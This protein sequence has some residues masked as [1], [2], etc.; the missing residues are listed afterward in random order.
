MPKSTQLVGNHAFTEEQ[1]GCCSLS[2]QQ[3]PYLNNPQGPA[4]H[5]INTNCFT[6]SSYTQRLPAPFL[7]SLPWLTPP[8]MRALRS[9]SSNAGACSHHKSS[10]CWCPPPQSVVKPM[11]VNLR[12]I[13]RYMAHTEYGSMP[14]REPL[15][16][17]TELWGLCHFQGPTSGGHSWQARVQTTVQLHSSHMPAKQ[18]SKFSKPGFNGM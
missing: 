9:Q 3:P 18:C 14:A 2:D 15:W 4:L 13:P 17:L 1:K 12:L 8:A 10:V 7:L 5:C 6:G 11:S 16:L